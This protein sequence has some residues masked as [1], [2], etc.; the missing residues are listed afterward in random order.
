MEK[1]EYTCIVCPRSC[2][3]NLSVINDSE[4]EVEGNICKR[5]E[6]YVINEYT[7]PK[8]M[9]TTTV[10]VENG[11]YANV[12]VVSDRAVEKSR[13]FEFLEHLYSIRFKAPLVGGDVLV[14]NILGSDVNILAARDMACK[15]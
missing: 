14:E 2:K 5:G 15:C 12:P 11:I 6:E 13:L 1:M 4:F 9:L 7:C 8:R 10:K 3:I